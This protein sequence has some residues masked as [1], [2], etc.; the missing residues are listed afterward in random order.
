MGR[1]DFWESWETNG[2]LQKSES[3]LAR[4]RPVHKHLKVLWPARQWPTVT[5]EKTQQ[6]KEAVPWGPCR[7]GPTHLSTA[8]SSVTSFVTVTKLFMLAK[9][10]LAQKVAVIV[11][12]R[13]CVLL[14]TAGPDAW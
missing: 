10:V 12:S 7:S 11:P 8:Y 14:R 3:H 5:V 13:C 1:A 2:S 4:M 9:F 6:L